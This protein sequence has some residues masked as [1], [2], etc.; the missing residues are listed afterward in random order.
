MAQNP[1]G[2]QSSSY[3]LNIADWIDI[4]PRDGADIPNGDVGIA[5]RA[6]AAG[7]IRYHNAWGDEIATSLS[8][9]EIFFT[10]VRRVLSTGTTATGIQAG[11]AARRSA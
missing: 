6:V 11:L 8:A 2:L 3:R 7:T 1:F 4:T 5:L 10:S 9:G